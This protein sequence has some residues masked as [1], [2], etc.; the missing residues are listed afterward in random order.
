[1]KI[2]TAFVRVVSLVVCAGAACHAPRVLRPTLVVSLLVCVAACGDP[3]PSRLQQRD[4]AEV[5]EVAPAAVPAPAPAA[6]ATAATP[7]PAKAEPEPTIPPPPSERAEVRLALREGASYRVT[8]IGNVRFGSLVQPTG[9]AREERVTLKGCAGEGYGRACKVEHRYVNFEAEP[10]NGRFLAN[11]EKAV[12]QLVTTHELQATGDRPGATTIA[13]PKEQAGSKAGQALAEVHRFYCLR[14]P[15]EPIGVGAKWRSKCHMR[16]G[17]VIDTRDVVWELQK[18]ERDP[19]TGLRAEIAY[20]GEYTAP[21]AKGSLQ[22][23]IRGMVLFF[24]DAG[25]PHLIREEFTTA[26]DS[27][28]K[29]VTH[30]SQVFQFV[31]LVAGPDGKETAVRVDGK[32]LPAVQPMNERPA[33]DAKAP[34]A[35]AGAP[36]EAKPAGEAKAAAPGG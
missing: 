9:F 28:S 29:Y 14:F 27:A 19:D 20:T 26:T 13:G 36:G 15:N 1:M 25:E 16:S 24:V 5:P 12:N 17:G 2:L 30:T 4:G 22:G 35:P 34:A 7:A 8:T 23:V 31:K 21:G 11:D 10:P 32:P 33:G 3:G 18:L 6:P